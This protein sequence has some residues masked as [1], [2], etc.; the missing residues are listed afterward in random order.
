[1]LKEK[2][3]SFMERV[4]TFTR[5]DAARVFN[6]NTAIASAVTL[7]VFWGLILN[8]PWWVTGVAVVS[9]A[10]LVGWLDG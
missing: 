6:F 4:S 9:F 7:L 2:L 3:E 10:L 1:M 5:K 8:A